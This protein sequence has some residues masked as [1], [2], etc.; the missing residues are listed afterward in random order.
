[1]PV[2][3]ADVTHF[4][5]AHER[6]ER[7]HRLLKGR[8]AVPLMDLIEVDDIGPE[9]LQ[10]RLA[11]ADQMPAGEAAVVGPLSHRIASLGRDQHAGLSFRAHRLAD[12]FLRGAGG[13][14]VCRVDQIDAGVGDDVD[15]P[16]HVVKLKVADLGEVPLAAEGHRAH[17]Q[18][19]DFK[20]GIAKLPVF[21][22]PL[23]LDARIAGGELTF[24][25]RRAKPRCRPTTRLLRLSRPR[26]ERRT[27]RTR[28]FMRICT[29][30][31]PFSRHQEPDLAFA[32]LRRLAF[33]ALLSPAALAAHGALAATAAPEPDRTVDMATVLKPGPLPELAVGDA[34]GVPVVEYGSLTCP[35]CATFSREVF[36]ELKKDYI[37][38]GKVRYIFREFPRNALD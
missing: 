25:L 26:L 4:P 13:I 11:F 29:L 17:G 2:R 6:V 5:R 3:A 37:D 18:D 33:A 22:R 15:Q 34:S 19:R 7:L 27:C 1:G 36:P 31:L 20:A 32:P 24:R 9:A 35:H 38:A 10:A 8:Q 21:H 12:Q 14:D 23:L 28:R 16:A 30:S